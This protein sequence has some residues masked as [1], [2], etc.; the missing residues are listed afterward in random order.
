[1]QLNVVIAH[2][3]KALEK[4]NMWLRQNASNTNNDLISEEGSK[5]K[6]YCK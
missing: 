6:D 3:D 4:Q 1:M 5:V 2:M